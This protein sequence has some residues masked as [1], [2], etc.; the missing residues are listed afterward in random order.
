MA[1]NLLSMKG[2]CKSFFGV[3]VFYKGKSLGRSAD[4]LKMQNLGVSMIH[5]E[6]NLIDELSIAQNIFLCREVQESTASGP[7]WYSVE[8]LPKTLTTYTGRRAKGSLRERK[9][10]QKMQKE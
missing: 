5:Q 2:I 1:G 9:F 8:T 6:L 7:D 4:P 10:L 3:E